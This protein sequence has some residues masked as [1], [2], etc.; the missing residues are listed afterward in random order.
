LCKR[1]KSHVIIVV[2]IYS[3]FHHS[4][5]PSIHHS[6]NPS[7][8][9]SIIPSIHHSINPS[10]HHFINPSFH[11]SVLTQI[12]NGCKVNEFFP[13]MQARANFFERK[14]IATL[15]KEQQS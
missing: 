6:I 14:I 3:S 4:I 2:L 5:N 15:R 9:Q 11:H 12:K 10:F 7:F 8:H 1:K 13:Y